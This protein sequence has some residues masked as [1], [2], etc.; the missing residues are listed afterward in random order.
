MG[1]RHQ[2]FLIA[3]LVPK[4]SATGQAY[5]RCIGVRH[6]QWC[7]EYYVPTALQRF[8]TLIKNPNNAEIIRDEIRRAQGVYPRQGDDTPVP[9]MPCPYTLMLLSMAWDMDLHSPEIAYSSGLGFE[10]YTLNPEMGSFDGHNN[11]GITIIDVTDPSDPGYCHVYRSGEPPTDARGYVNHYETLGSVHTRQFEIEV[12]DG[13]RN[14]SARELAEVWPDEYLAFIN[15]GP[16]SENVDAKTQNQATQ[17]QTIPSLAD[18]AIA[19][20]LDHALATDDIEQLEEMIWMPGK[21]DLMK[22][23]L[24]TKSPLP[25]NAMSLLVKILTH[26]LGSTSRFILD[27]SVFPS[28]SHGQVGS[29]VNALLNKKPNIMSLNLSGNH[30]ICAQTI[31]EV[32]SA[33]PKLTR[34]V[35]LNTSI[36]DDQLLELMSTSPKLFYNLYD[37]VHPAF[38]RPTLGSDIDSEHIKAETLHPAYNHGLTFATIDDSIESFASTPI[39]HPVKLLRTL[40]RHLKIH[41]WHE[42]RRDFYFNW[43]Y[44]RS[45]MGPLLTLSTGTSIA[46]LRKQKAEAKAGVSP[47]AVLV[48][49][50]LDSENRW[51]SRSITSVPRTFSVDGFL[52]VGWMFIL[53]VEAPYG[54][55]QERKSPAYGFVKVDREAVKRRAK[56]GNT[57][58]DT[59]VSRVNR[60]KFYELISGLYNIYDVRGFISE[61]EKEGRP[62]PRGD[63]SIFDIFEK[64]ALV[65]VNDLETAFNSM[66]YKDGEDEFWGSA[67]EMKMNDN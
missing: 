57:G 31:I 59:S 7:W 42:Q 27:L 44:V 49:K 19:P 65:T 46:Q 45:G 52:G 39:F 50:G 35:L 28:L 12:L 17:G 62:V 15:P 14:L 32:L 58:S 24:V 2:I 26:E 63:S 36:A 4:G 66:S 54:R 16:T 18:L 53:K 25:D 40:V 48:D 8:L 10:R 9:L 3:R 21:A 29:L 11:D 38:L 30:N 34:L 23:V 1:Q 47:G 22:K 60:S 20:A 51:N 41:L 33:L 43:S 13:V 6:H 56:E 37:L 61:M 5:Y 67:V 55:G 64:C